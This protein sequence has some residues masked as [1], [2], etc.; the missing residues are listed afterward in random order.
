MRSGFFA[1]GLSIPEGAGI[2]KGKDQFPTGAGLPTS[3]F[4]GVLKRTPSF[5]KKMI[6]FHLAGS[7]FSLTTSVGPC[8]DETR[9]E[10][11]LVGRSSLSAIFLTKHV[12][13]LSRFLDA[14]LR[15]VFNQFYGR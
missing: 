1:K 6:L 5:P 15:T 7:P 9:R 8:Q 10:G 14:I 4:R 13:I 11:K 3:V 2:D 12:Q